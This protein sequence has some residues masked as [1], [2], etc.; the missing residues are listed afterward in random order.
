MSDPQLTDDEKATLARIIEL[1]DPRSVDTYTK[2]STSNVS[3]AAADA[4]P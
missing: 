4:T 2:D 3:N 1:F